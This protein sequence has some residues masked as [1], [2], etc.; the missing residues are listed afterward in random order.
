MK[1]ALEQQ[2]NLHVLQAEA[3]GILTKNGRACGIETKSGTRISAD[4]VIVT[5]GTFLK[6]LIH[7][8]LTHFPGGRFNE[9][10]SET[11][12]ASL[13]G[14]GFE[15]KRLKTGTPPR[16]NG[17]SIDYR[18]MTT[19][20]GV[21]PPLPFSYFTERRPWQ[22]SKKQLP[23][24]LTYTNEETHAVIRDN[25]DRSPLYAGIIKSIGPR[26]CPSIEDKVVR[27][28]ERARHQVFL[29]PEGYSTLE[30]YANGISTS[31]P[32]DVQERIVHSIAGCEHAEILR[33][34]YAIEYDF[35]PPTQLAPTLETKQVEHLYFAGQI[36]GT[37]G[38]EEAAAQGLIAGINASL[39][40]AGDEPFVLHRDES[41]IGVLIDDLVT[42][43]V[44]EPYR[45]FTSR[46]EYRLMLRSDNADLRL[47]DHG[48]RLGLISEEH[49]QAFDRYRNTVRE[50]L[51]SDIIPPVSDDAFRPWTWEQVEEE[52]MI[53]KKYAGYIG[54][55]KTQVAKL[56]KMDEKKIPSDFNYDTIPSLLTETRQ[57]LKKIRP[58]TLGQA[59]RVSGVTPADAAILLLHLE[60]KKK[61]ID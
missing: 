18:V 12:S 55:Q 17:K 48:R 1:Q 9:F 61:K 58:T 27:F 54:R 31:L 15:V 10:P 25:L 2:Q 50:M 30:L 21:E 3:V 52:V 43:G 14:L 23:C 7:V 37:T 26:Y 49:Y 44:D 8:G 39:K 20:P 28:K 60:K 35:C 34:G 5:T 56:K 40:L 6:G 47:M 19:Q 32:E 53:E 16:L 11:L 33:Y 42:K 51:E 36:N 22:A 41:Y 13:A 38:Y 24:W 57:K 45:M 59:L 46:A 29:E 4:A